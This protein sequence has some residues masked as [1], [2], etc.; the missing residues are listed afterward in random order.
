MRSD[1]D[2]DSLTATGLAIVS[3]GGTLVD[4]G[5]GTWTYTPAPN[6]SSSVE[7]QLHDR[8]RQRRHGRGQ[9]DAGS[10]AGQRR[11]RPRRR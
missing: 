4:N 10:H 2:G 5:N 8:R 11:A 3:G 7:L 1:I 6:D 9:R